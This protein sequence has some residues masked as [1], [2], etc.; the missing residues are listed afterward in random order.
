MSPMQKIIVDLV[1]FNFTLKCSSQFVFL[2]QEEGEE[3]I[4]RMRLLLLLLHFLSSDILSQL[5]LSSYFTE[6]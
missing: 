2:G 1:S 6:L 4:D 3:V 5:L